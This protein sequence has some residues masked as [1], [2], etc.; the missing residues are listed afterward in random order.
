MYIGLNR[1]KYWTEKEVFGSLRTLHLPRD[2][3]L[4]AVE[5]T[6]VNI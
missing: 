3:D 6:M 5:T 2:G 1:V 4:T